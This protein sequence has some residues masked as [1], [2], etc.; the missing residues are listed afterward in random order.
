[1]FF[2]NYEDKK[3]LFYITYTILL[4]IAVYNYMAVFTL[5]GLVLNLLL[6]F[7]LGISIAFILNVLLKIIE[8]RLFNDN[9]KY[10]SIAFVSKLKRALSLILTLVVVFGTLVILSVIIVPEMQTTFSLVVQRAP[11]LVKETQRWINEFRLNLRLDF[12]PEITVN[13]SSIGQSISQ[14]LQT[15]GL[16]FFQATT[17]VIVTIVNIS[18]GFVFAIYVLLQKETLKLHT[19][20]LLYAYFAKARIDRIVEIGRLSSSIFSKF[21]VG[22][23]LEAIIIGSLCFIGMVVLRI[24]YA[25]TISALV[26]ITAL[27]PVVGA[28]IGTGVGALLIATISP[29]QA[30]I[31]V[32]YIIVIQQ[33]DGNFIYPKVVGNAI[34]LPSI[35]V[36]AAVTLGASISGVIG[37][38]LAV[39]ICSII[40]SILR[41]DV[42][43]RLSSKDLNIK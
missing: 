2:K 42:N 37:M 31:F 3:V 26:T 23:L 17:S 18:I 22:Q 9:Y 8:T 39:P 32:V 13:W 1:M 19:K 16:Q 35:W 10:M 20:K 11:D 27:V 14:F 36:L 6:P 30:V 41:V 4:L 24:P 21:I 33:I 43:K 15:G 28:F 40:Y 38:L 29:I 5:I 34:G 7:I 25:G 12:L